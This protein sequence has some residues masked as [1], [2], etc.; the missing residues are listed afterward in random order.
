MDLRNQRRS[1]NVRRGRTPTRLDTFLYG[2]MRGEPGPFA[3]ERPPNVERESWGYKWPL[4]RDSYPEYQNIPAPNLQT[5]PDRLRGR[6]G[7]HA[8]QGGAKQVVNTQ[9]RPGDFNQPME[10][11]LPPPN[12]PDV[13]L[14]LNPATQQFERVQQLPIARP[15]EPRG[16]NI[17]DYTQ[18]RRGGFTID[19]TDPEALIQYRRRF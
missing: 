15:E 2:D 7:Q 10:R 8:L 16:R 14:V 9:R 3:Y 1:E 5:G 13:A 4:P 17:E 18:L 6:G 12:R 11:E 19:P